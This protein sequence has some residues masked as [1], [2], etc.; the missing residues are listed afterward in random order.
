MTSK[1]Y[2]P[3]KLFTK[4]RTPSSLLA[5]TQMPLP[6]EVPPGAARPLFSPSIHHWSYICS[7]SSVLKV[8]SQVKIQK[9]DK[10][11]SGRTVKKLKYSC[12][13]IWNFVRFK[14]GPA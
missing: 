12:K 9:L 10:D 1:N 14:H 7:V 6:L 13:L 5:S 8:V 3:D 11:R 4:V 2:L